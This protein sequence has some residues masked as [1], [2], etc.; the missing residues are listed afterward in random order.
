MQI[1]QETLQRKLSVSVVPFHVS[2][3]CPGNRYFILAM[4][5]F[6]FEAFSS[7]SINNLLQCLVKVNVTINANVLSAVPFN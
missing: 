7:F 3:Q 1:E 4:K 5:S 6:S 2:D